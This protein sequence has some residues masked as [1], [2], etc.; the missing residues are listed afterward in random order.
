[1]AHYKVGDRILS[2]EEY[3]ED[4]IHKWGLVLFVIVALFAGSAMNSIL[5][6]EWP[7]YV[8]FPVVIL[9]GGVAGTIAAYFVRPIRQVATWAILIAVLGGIGYGIWT[10]M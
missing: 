9:V 4:N 3:E 10:L 7:K 2:Q 1:M 6:D 8:R 5:P